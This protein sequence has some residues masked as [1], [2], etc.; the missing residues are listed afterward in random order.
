MPCHVASIDSPLGPLT[1]VWDETGVRHL[2]LPGQRHSP[3]DRTE[4][5]PHEGAGHPA[6]QAALA[7]LSGQDA[8]AGLLLAP[9]GTA[10]QQRVWAVLQTI[11]RGELRTYAQVADAIGQPGSVRAVGAAIG[12]NPLPLLIPCHRVV[13][14]NGNLTGFSGGIAAKRWLLQRE[15]IALDPLRDRLA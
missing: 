3:S 13:G 9:A 11:P 10:F 1:L 12:R 5:L 8:P 14:S 6:M 15:G 4:W 7:L 2:L